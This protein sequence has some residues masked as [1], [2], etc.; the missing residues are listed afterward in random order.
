M[1][2]HAEE[3]RES[4]LEAHEV[5]YGNKDIGDIIPGIDCIEEEKYYSRLHIPFMHLCVEIEEIET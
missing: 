4:L 3:V 2:W 5:G 1:E